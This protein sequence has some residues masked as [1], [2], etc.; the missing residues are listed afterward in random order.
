MDKAVHTFTEVI[1]PKVNIIVWLKFEPTYYD[2][3]I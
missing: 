2:L 3:A 1:S